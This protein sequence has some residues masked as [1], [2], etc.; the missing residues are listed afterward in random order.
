MKLRFV[1]AIATGAVVAASLAL[2]ATGA[3][4]QDKTLSVGTW[5]WA[6]PVLGDWWK[7]VGEKFE[8]DNPGVKL[9]VRNL[10]VNDYMTQVVIEVASGNPADVVSA[11]VNL[12]E[13]KDSGG[14]VP[15]NDLIERSGMRERIEEACW[16]ATTF[17]GQIMAV[18]IAGRT[19][20]LLYNEAKFKEA[21]I[22]GPPTSPAE[23]LDAARKLTVKDAS[24]KTTQYGASMVHINEEPSF[25]MLMMWSIAFGGRL[26]DGTNPTLTD[27]AVVEALTFMKTLYDE[28]LIPRGRSEDDQRALFAAGTT[29]ME[30]DGP[31]Q[32]PF[33]AKVNPEMVSSIIATRLP[34]DGPATGGPNVLLA[35]GNT[36]NQE[37]A[38]KFIETVVSPE[39]QQE[40]PKYA[41]TVPCAVGAINDE[42]LKAKPYLAAEL[43]HFQEGPVRNLPAGFENVASEF[44]AIVLEAM[45]KVI[46]GGGDPATELAA[47]QKELEAAFD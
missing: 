12:A 45:T 20:V 46:Q 38:W 43:A 29:A 6:Q 33:V 17:D 1:N 36:A 19:L 28:E 11:S 35:V 13:I 41:D 37:L 26:T 16:T 42:A 23:F 4:A 7:M 31:W 24:G 14:I 3:V 15:L 9:D 5:Y 30:L 22:A 21:G 44:Q 32:V 2:A 10:P 34:W 18:P 47:A 40:F 39:L 27:P 8:A 25:E